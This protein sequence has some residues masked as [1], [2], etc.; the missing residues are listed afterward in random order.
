MGFQSINCHCVHTP[1]VNE[2]I[3]GMSLEER[4]ALQQQAID[5]MNADPSWIEELEQQNRAK[6]G[7]EGVSDWNSVLRRRFDT[8]SAM[9]RTEKLTYFKGNTKKFT[10]FD[11]GL[12]DTP[13]KLNK[14]RNY[15]LTKIKESG[16][17]NAEDIEKALGTKYTKNAV[18]T[19]IKIVTH[20]DL[21]DKP[22]SITQYVKPS[23]GGIDRNYYDAGGVQYKQI[24]NH[25][26]GSP[27]FH[28]QNGHSHD[29]YYGE[30][31]ELIRSLRELTEEEKEENGDI[32]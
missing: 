7:I 9:S 24:S 25:D 32:L 6:A 23:T 11:S 18:G 15:S 26:H 31:G 1:I 27:K 8:F 30:N 3:I 16:I 22:N 21:K 17:I 14:L 2:Q 28:P 12:V 10:L 19:P 20:T 29:Y 4:R 13:E 5:E